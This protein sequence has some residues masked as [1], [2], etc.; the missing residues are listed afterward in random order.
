M[1]ADSM[2]AIRSVKESPE[3]KKKETR[4]TSQSDAMIGDLFDFQKGLLALL[5][6]NCTHRYSLSTFKALVCSLKRFLD[7]FH[8]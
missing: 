6:K 3:D 2:H 4:N 5:M 1:L 8:A 7:N